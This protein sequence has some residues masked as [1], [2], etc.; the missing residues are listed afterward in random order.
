[1]RKKTRCRYI[2]YT[3]RLTARVLLYAPFHRQDNTYHGI[4]YTSR[5]ALAGTR[6]SSMGPSHEGSIRRPTA[7]WANARFLAYRHVKTVYN[8]KGRECFIMTIS[9]HF[10]YGYMK[11][12]T[13]LR[14]TQIVRGNPPLS[15]YWLVFPISSKV[16]LFLYAPFYR[17][18][19][20]Y[21]SLCYISL[22]TLGP[23]W[24]IDPTCVCVCV[25]VCV[26]ECH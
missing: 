8:R 23:P 1:M 13:G 14:T 12:Y 22:N 3:Y 21:H 4:C 10:L 16:F 2:G 6:N 26:L 5:G 19:G 11:S 7:P 15:I 20:T 25:C 17:Q 18:D 24:R 9:A